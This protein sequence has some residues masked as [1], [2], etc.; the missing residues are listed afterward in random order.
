MSKVE[1]LCQLIPAL[2]AQIDWTRGITKKTKDTVVYVFKNGSKMDILAARESSRGQRRNGG[3]MEECILIDKD[4]LNEVIIPTTNVDRLLPDGTRDPSEVVNKSQVYVTT[5][6]WANSFAFD[7]LIELLIQSIVDPDQ[8]I[9]LGGTYETPVAEGLLQKD[10]VN[11]LK[12]AGTFDPESFDRQYRSIWSGNAAGAFFDA[13]VI[14]KHRILQLARSQ[15]DK[16]QD[17]AGFYLFGIDVGRIGCTTEICVFYI[18]PLSRGGYNKSLINIY[19]YE[20]EHFQKQ[21]IYIK[22]LFYKFNPRSIA[23]DANGLGIGL[24]DFLTTQNYDEQRDEY[25]PPFGVEN[26]EKGLYKKILNNPSAEQDVLW[27][28]KPDAPFNTE[29]YSYAQ[30]QLRAGRIKLL[31]DQPTARTRLLDTKVG[32]A[33]GASQ[34]AEYLKPYVHTTA[35]RA[36]MLNLVQENDGKNIILK[37]DT[38]SIKKDKF[39]AFI[40][41]LSYVKRLEDQGVRQKS[42]NF[43]DMIFFTKNG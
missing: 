20:A 38:H 39:S 41:G 33:M 6:G 34:R 24:I 26:D 23:I 25:F 11:S 42:R 7:K 13:D 43:K 2:R 37:Q 15:E 9:V 1:Q 35:L 17:K 30:T 31:V 8:A 10:F 14:D 27:I 4:I 19:S 32:M 3:I 12:I 5:A 21:A 16:R 22:R 18:T 29:C 28:I 36:Q 40:Y